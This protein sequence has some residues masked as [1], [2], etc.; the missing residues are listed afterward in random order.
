MVLVTAII[1]SCED[2]GKG[3]R[4]TNVDVFF[5]LKVF[6]N[7]RCIVEDGTGEAMVFIENDDLVRRVLFANI[8]TWDEIKNMSKKHGGVCYQR[9]A[10]WKASHMSV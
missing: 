8:S 10:Y 9:A 7:F 3:V 1:F 6:L 2:Q 4:C 5:I